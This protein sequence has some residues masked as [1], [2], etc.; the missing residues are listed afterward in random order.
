[1]YV[2]NKVPCPKEKDD[3]KITCSIE[4]SPSRNIGRERGHDTSIGLLHV[5]L[6]LSQ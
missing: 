3:T 4:H 2:L 5:I 6:D 1:M